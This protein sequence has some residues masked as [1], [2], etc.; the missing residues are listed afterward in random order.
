MNDRMGMTG[1]IAGFYF[2]GT[3]LRLVEGVVLDH[4][5]AGLYV[6]ANSRGVMGAGLAADIRRAAGAE[7]ER[8]LRSHAELLQGEAYLTS[9]GELAERGVEAIAHGVVASEP[10]GASTLDVSIKAL[11]AGLRLLEA[12]GCRTVTIPQVGWR[13]TDL[14]H[15]TA[16][17]ELAWAIV[18]HLRRNSRLTTVAI[19][20]RH[21]D[22][23]MA[24]S[25]ALREMTG[26][27]P[28]SGRGSGS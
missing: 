28:E 1:Y 6:G 26:V 11:L 9:G 19:V 22:Y 2:G 4:L 13:V 14:S 24:L 8:E 7:V 23:Q 3:Q 15:E 18:T 5:H 17:A 16:A 27:D 25:A 21:R 20:S 10:G 12:A